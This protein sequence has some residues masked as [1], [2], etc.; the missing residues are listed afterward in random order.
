MKGF[1]WGVILVL[2][3]EESFAILKK[4]T[5]DYIG[6]GILGEVFSYNH[7]AK[8]HSFEKYRVNHEKN[9]IQ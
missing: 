2:K 6:R 9:N 4:N 3:N 5:H 7:G 8:T 1:I